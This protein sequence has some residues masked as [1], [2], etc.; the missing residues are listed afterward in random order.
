M[1]NISDSLSVIYGWA[2]YCHALSRCCRNAVSVIQ[3]ISDHLHTRSKL[4]FEI[5]HTRWSPVLNL[6]L[7]LVIRVL[8]AD[9]VGVGSLSLRH[10]G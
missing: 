6:L 1:D 9:R 3:R 8:A 4:L 5:G 7:R 2:T 10:N